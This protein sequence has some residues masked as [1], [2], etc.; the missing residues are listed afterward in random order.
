MGKLLVEMKS[1]TVETVS[2]TITTTTAYWFDFDK[3]IKTDVTIAEYEDGT[4][5]R[6]TTK[7]YFNSREDL[8]VEYYRV[9]EIKENL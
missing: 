1:V 2:H 8:T 5:R 4:I 9:K 6:Y 3:L 7:S